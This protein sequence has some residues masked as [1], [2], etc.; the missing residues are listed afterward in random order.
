MARNTHR[1]MPNG[2]VMQRRTVART[3]TGPQQRLEFGYDWRGRRIMKNV[4]NN[5]EGTGA[6]VEPN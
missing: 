6:S 1:V 4:W 2:E 3:G 5:T